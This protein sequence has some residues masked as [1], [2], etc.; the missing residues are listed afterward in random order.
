MRE[1]YV[2][3]EVEILE[4]GLLHGILVG[5]DGFETPETDDGFP[6]GDE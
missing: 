5:S 1:P 4:V 2:F 3:P 6:G